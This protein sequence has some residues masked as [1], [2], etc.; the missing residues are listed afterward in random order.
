MKQIEDIESL[1][2]SLKQVE[3]IEPS[4]FMF[5]KIKHKIEMQKNAPH[6]FNTK[7]LIVSSFALLMIVIMNITIIFYFSEQN[8]ADLQASSSIET[9][10]YV[11]TTDQY[12][13]NY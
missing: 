6:E 13:Y 9:E 10:Q 3:Q 12:Y 1:I 8:Q 5:A 11:V 2:D 7:F 4:P